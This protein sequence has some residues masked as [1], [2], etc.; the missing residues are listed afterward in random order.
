[1]KSAERVAASLAGEFREQLPL[2]FCLPN[3]A[4]YIKWFIG[5]LEKLSAALDA[6]A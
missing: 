5:S 2:S 1:M 3:N 6:L 4:D